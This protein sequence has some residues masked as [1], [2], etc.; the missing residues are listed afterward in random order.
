MCLEYG[1]LGNPKFVLRA[2]TCPSLWLSH[3]GWYQTIDATLHI[4]PVS[5]SVLPGPTEAIPSHQ[6]DTTSHQ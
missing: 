4:K 2:C 5:S 3:L 6:T 1:V